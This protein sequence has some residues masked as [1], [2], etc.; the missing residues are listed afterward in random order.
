[1]PSLEWYLGVD[2]NNDTV[3]TDESARLKHVKTSRGRKFY[4]RSDNQGFYM[5]R[6]GNMTVKL[7]NTDQRFNPYL[8][9]EIT[10]G[11]P[12]IL[13][14]SYA[15]T[16]YDVLTG[17]VADIQPSKS[18]GLDIATLTGVDGMRYL[19]RAK[20]TTAL[21]AGC[22]IHEAIQ[23]VLAASSWPGGSAIDTVTDPLAYHWASG[24]T[25][26]NEIEKLVDASLGAFFIA[27][28]G[29]AKY[30]SRSRARVP[31]Q[32]LSET[33]VMRDTIRLPQPWEIVRN[34]ITLKVYTRTLQVSGDLWTLTDKPQVRTGRSLTVWGQYSFG[35][36]RCPAT[37]VIN[38]TTP[39]D[40]LINTQ[41]DGGG[42]NL[43]PWCTVTP[44]I[45]GDTIKLVIVN[46]SAFD[47]YVTLL[48]VRGQ[49]LTTEITVLNKAAATPDSMFTID[50]PW[51]QD[52][53]LSND[54][55]TMLYN[56]L[57]APRAYPECN[58][59]RGQPALQFTPDLFDIVTL[60]FPTYSVADDYQVSDIAHSW[61]DSYGRVVDTHMCFEPNPAGGGAGWAGFWFFPGTLDL[62]KFGG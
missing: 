45:F 43:S 17:R 60:T 47:G 34:D 12:F 5:P 58:I 27:G 7:V 56:F 13:Q 44:S 14:T 53:V 55:L 23:D 16:D 10:T 46:G 33:T 9:P 2:W 31:V 6:V 49:A 8:H 42:V 48:K 52:V 20:A 57:V 41:A 3:Y 1:M 18:A 26:F 25:A 32:T 19:E 38:P 4:L 24:N 59:L 61:I 50:N 51:L 62:D 21:H 36:E 30:Y 40:W 28:D 15:G 54:I 39:T 22:Y 35:N 11:A 29:R 37:G